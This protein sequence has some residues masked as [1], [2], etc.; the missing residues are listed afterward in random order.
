[1]KKKLSLLTFGLTVS[2]VLFS[3]SVTYA[4][5]S[6]YTAPSDTLTTETAP[7]FLTLDPISKVTCATSAV[8]TATR[9]PLFIIRLMD[10]KVCVIT[11]GNE[12]DCRVLSHIDPRT[13]RTRDL[14]LLREGIPLYS[15][16]ELQI[17]LEDFSS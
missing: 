6:L 10:G 4:W 9:H 7:V 11:V 14:N 17:F 16:T 1:M 12:K 2:L 8:Q 5:S 13:L 15:Q 3:V